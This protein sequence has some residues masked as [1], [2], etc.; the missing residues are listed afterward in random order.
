[1]K[2]DAF[3]PNFYQSSMLTITHNNAKIRADELNSAF[4]VFND[5]EEGVYS[6]LRQVGTENNMSL[7]S[8]YFEQRH[9]SSLVDQLA[10]YLDDEDEA[11]RMLLI[12][13]DLK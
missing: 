6:V 4:G 13:K 7:V 11:K 10:Y 12:A 2:L 5:D 8:K 3:N 1:M 9:N